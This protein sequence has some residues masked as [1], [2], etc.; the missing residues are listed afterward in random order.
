MISC[1]QNLWALPQLLAVQLWQL[2][3]QKRFIK[4]Y[5]A[6]QFKG[7]TPSLSKQSYKKM[8]LYYGLFVPG[9]LGTAFC[10]LRSKKI[11]HNE[12]FVLSLQGMLTGI[13]DDFFDENNTA[14]DKIKSL[15]FKP[16]SSTIENNEQSVFNILSREL[17]TNAPNP[18]MLLSY[19]QKVFNAQRASKKQKKSNLSLNEIKQITAQKGGD[20][21]LFY[22][23]GLT[24]ELKPYEE[25][26]IFA[27]GDCMQ[28]ANDIFDIYEDY[29]AN[30]ATVATKCTSIDELTGAFL[31][32][33]NEVK[34]W[35]YKTPYSKRATRKF[36]RLVWLTVFSRTLVCLNML[37]KL[38]NGIEKKFEINTYTRSQLICDMEKPANIL[39]GFWYFISS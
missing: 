5:I 9:V 31:Q 3:R 13:F 17:V 29:K 23:M 15:I 28:W 35:A 37:K 34:I 14:S 30:I 4:K 38:E 2:F 22:R 8:T 36:L 21:F 27:L 20:S 1:L 12:R 18:K 32:K 39:R 6:K 24:N 19:S 11:R 33:A 25:E 7:I 10:A 16:F 26:L